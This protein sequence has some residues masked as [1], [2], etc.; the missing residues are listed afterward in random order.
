MD[1]GNAARNDGALYGV[2]SRRPDAI[3]RVERS[4]VIAR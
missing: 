1:I 2:A 3:L 4:F